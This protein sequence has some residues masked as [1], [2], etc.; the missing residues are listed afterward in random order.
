MMLGW[1]K[2]KIYI[3]LTVVT[4]YEIAALH[5]A[6]NDGAAP[7]VNAHCDCSHGATIGPH[8]CAE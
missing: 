5:I 1:R 6:F 4:T 8:H 3:L 2:T 7:C